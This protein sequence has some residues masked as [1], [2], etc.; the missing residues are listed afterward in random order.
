MAKIINISS[1]D[2]EQ[3][4]LKNEKPV[5]VDFWAEWCGP[6]KAIAPL[7]EELAQKQD[8]VVI[9]KLDVQAHQAL[10]VQY[11]VMSIPT[12]ILFEKGESKQRIIG[13]DTQAIENLISSYKK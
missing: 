5:L 3:Q 13:A 10:A 9:V 11:Q 7:L 4:V 1:Q 2:F 6:C 12:L 8:E